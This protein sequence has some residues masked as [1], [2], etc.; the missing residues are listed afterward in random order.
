[1]IPS[2]QESYTQSSTRALIEQTEAHVVV[3]LLLLL[4]LL[5]LRG[6]SSGGGIRG[7]GGSGDERVGVGEVLLGLKSML[8]VS[9]FGKTE[10]D[11][12]N[13]EG[14]KASEDA[15]NFQC[16]YIDVII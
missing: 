12:I 6:S 14:S 9:L 3:R 1:M 15:Q 13:K 8:L 7:G 4:S 2:I 16:V 11:I 10:S 5:L